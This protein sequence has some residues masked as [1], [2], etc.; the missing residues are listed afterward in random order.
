MLRASLSL[1]LDNE[2]SYRKTRGDAGWV[3]LP[4]YL[5]KVVTRF[6]TL[7]DRH[8]L[9]VTVFVVGQDAERPENAA[10]LA[11]LAASRHEIGNHS[12]HHEPWIT[13]RSRDDVRTELVRAQTAI[14]AATG[15][16]PVGFRGPGYATSPAILEVLT[17]LDF[18]YDCSA[19]PTFIGPLARAYYF[20][21]TKMTPEERKLREGLF[22]TWADAMQTIRPHR[23]PGTDLIE[24]PVTTFPGLRIPINLSY[25]L[26]ICE[27][28][29]WLGMRYF[30]SALDACRLAR[31]EPSLLLHPLDVL[32]LTDVPSLAFFPAMAMP[33]AKKIGV[34]DWALSALSKRFAVDSVG[35]HAR[36][37]G[38][39]V[40][41]G[42]V[43]RFEK[44]RVGEAWK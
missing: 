8:G 39:K 27:F 2:W 4:T 10:A 34:L 22:G 23:I 6:L 19:L 9:R 33:A 38:A 37:H 5:E 30:E 25:V 13:T 14:V 41:S 35:E 20:M 28:S 21:R 32:D 26:Y 29:P 16:R 7:L 3:T 1:D 15:R 42:T 36:A 44:W 31:V 12:F 40:D 18:A 43:A 24:I 17:E 11:M